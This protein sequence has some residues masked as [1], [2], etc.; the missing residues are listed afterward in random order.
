MAA[1]P[2]GKLSDLLR[3]QVRIHKTPP[4]VQFTQFQKYAKYLLLLVTTG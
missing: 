1:L 3:K 4:E 2:A